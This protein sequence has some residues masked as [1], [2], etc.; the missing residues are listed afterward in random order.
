MAKLKRKQ[1]PVKFPRGYE[2]FRKSYSNLRTRASLA[3]CFSCDFFYQAEGDICEL[4][5]NPSVLKYDMVV[6][7]NRVFCSYWRGVWERDKFMDD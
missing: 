7:K 2:V 1:K 4:C 3:N 6:D 5:Q